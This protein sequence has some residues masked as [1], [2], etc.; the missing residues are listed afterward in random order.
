MLFNWS[1][2]TDYRLLLIIYEIDNHKTLD[3][4]L[5]IDYQYQS[6][7][8]HRLPSIVID[9]RLHRLVTP[10]SIETK[11]WA[12][13][14]G[15]KSTQTSLILRQRP[16]KSYKLWKCFISFA[17]TVKSR[18]VPTVWKKLRWKSLFVF[19][20]AYFKEHHKS[21]INFKSLYDF[22]GTLPRY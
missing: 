3:D 22:W 6:I 13:K 15:L 12:L 14:Y 2:L 17:A 8:C 21:Y 20:F 19:V 5:F 18:H 9:H 4:R 7:N 1:I 16:P 10:W 11:L